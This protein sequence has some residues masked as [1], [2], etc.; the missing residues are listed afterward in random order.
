MNSE[1]DH[2]SS[3]QA[4]YGQTV[5]LSIDEITIPAVELHVLVGPNGYSKC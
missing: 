1:K 2:L 5:G 4:S 3:P